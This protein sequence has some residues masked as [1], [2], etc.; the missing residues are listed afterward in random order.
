[1]GTDNLVFLEMIEWFDEEWAKSY[2][3]LERIG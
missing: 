2:N 1:M 3:F